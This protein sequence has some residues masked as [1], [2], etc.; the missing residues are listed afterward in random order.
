M[1]GLVA[2]PLRWRGE[3]WKG[4]PREVLT[5]IFDQL[6]L[7][8]T[9]E[10]IYSA[11][12]NLSACLLVCHSFYAASLPVFYR[13]VPIS[14]SGQF[15]TF[16]N[17]L[18]AY[19]GHGVLVQCLD[20]SGFSSVGLGRTAKYI[21]EVMNLTATTLREC[22]ELTPNLREFL[23]NVHM[24]DD[25]DVG[26][27]EALFAQRRLEAVDFCACSSEAFA[28]AFQALA[29]KALPPLRRISFH[30]CT[31][32]PPA[33]FARLLP[34]LPQ[35]THL[36]ISHTR[37]AAE[38]L[39]ALSPL[40]RLSHLGLAKCFSVSGEAL[41]TFLLTHPAASQLSFL[42]LSSDPF[43]QQHLTPPLLD[44]VLPRLPHTLTHLN[45]GGSKLGTQH[46]P[47]LPRS[48]I[49][50]SI[51]NCDVDD[52]D[53]IALIDAPDCRLEYLDITGIASISA[54]RINYIPTFHH[55][56]VKVYEISEQLQRDLRKD[57][58][59]PPWDVVLGRGKRG[60]YVRADE[61]A[62]AK[63]IPRWGSH[64]VDCCESLE[65]VRGIYSYYSFS[66]S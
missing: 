27:L 4:L 23:V 8:R 64:K 24:Q 53:I 7:D 65:Q 14:H 36:D 43:I 31:R 48:L 12:R 15:S 38:T 35:L 30:E 49:E 50:L 17:H 6:L 25:F 11:L 13:H 22:L 46:L 56:T 5:N 33:V 16:L 51:A 2:D 57:I 55:S 21:A 9:T 19:P 54:F 28:R 44:A 41:A 32:L 42:N 37:I 20:F 61:I 40:A 59:N 66:L 29:P 62:R 63:G 1:P 60:W 10:T 26:V 58:A 3:C 18:K 52:N 45:L 47:L 39:L 34:R